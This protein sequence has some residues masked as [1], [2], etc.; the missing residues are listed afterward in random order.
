MYGNDSNFIQPQINARIIRI[1][2]KQQQELL[3]NSPDY[4]TPIIN[5]EDPLDI[6]VDIEG[7]KD[8]PY[9]GGLF[10][11]KLFIPSEFPQIAPKGNFLTKIF[12]PNISEKGE[13]CVNTLKKD[14]NPRQ[15]SLYNLFEVI[16]CLLI[17]PFPQSSLNEEAGKIFMENYQEYFNIAKIYTKIH[18]TKNVQN[19]QENIEKDVEMK[20][21]ENI[22]NN[23]Y[24]NN[25]YDNNNDNNNNN[26]NNYPENKNING[27]ERDE[28]F[29]MDNN[30]TNNDSN[31]EDYDKHEI[32]KCK[33]FGFPQ[34]NFNYSH[35]NNSNIDP[36]LDELDNFI[37]EEKPNLGALHILRTN[38]LRGSNNISNYGF[39][40]S[41]TS[42]IT[43]EQ[44]IKR[45]HREEINKW[46]MRI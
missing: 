11:V 35:N 25:N 9:E 43:D 44:L 22:E 6:Q 34:R 24:N 30:R 20:P 41:R 21:I 3:K 23:N 18:A 36:E 5:N 26:L 19:K 37:E 46:L 7:P 12:H 31:M 2:W 8:T 33:S 14:W 45:N 13:I 40:R 27:N 28:Y 29:Q 10:R 39:F 4:I 16:K 1:L 32:L 17:V 42:E 15:W 38:S